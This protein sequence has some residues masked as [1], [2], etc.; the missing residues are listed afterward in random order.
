MEKKRYRG[1]FGY[2]RRLTD[3]SLTTSAEKTFQSRASGLRLR[4]ILLTPTQTVM[5]ARDERCI[6]C[7]QTSQVTNP[8]YCTL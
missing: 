4:I 3:I 2:R 1:V 7:S 6:S 5:S 8:N